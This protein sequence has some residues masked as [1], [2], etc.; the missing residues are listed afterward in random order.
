MSSTLDGAVRRWRPGANADSE[1]PTCPSGHR[2]V[3]ER[4]QVLLFFEARGVPQVLRGPGSRTAF[5]LDGSRV[6]AAW[7]AALRS[8]SAARPGS[9]REMPFGVPLSTIQPRVSLAASFGM[10]IE[11]ARARAAGSSFAPT[12]RP[13]GPAVVGRVPLARASRV[14]RLTVQKDRRARSADVFG[15]AAP[16]VP[17]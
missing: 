10:S 11:G 16:E 5:G 14:A 9:E 8:G 13:S 15:T 1:T 4:S 6:R 17:G 7:P 12:A 3:G 2:G